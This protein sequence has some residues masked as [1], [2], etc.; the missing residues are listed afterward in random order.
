M[1]GSIKIE[2]HKQQGL[3]DKLE[4]ETKIDVSF[5]GLAVISAMIAC[6]SLLIEDL[7]ILIG[8]MLIAPF[9][10]PP[11]AVGMGLVK[12]DLRLFKKGLITLVF[13]V[14]IG[15]LGVIIVALISPIKVIGDEIMARSAPTLIQLIIAILAG[16][17]GAFSY[18][19]R[20]IQAVLS[21]AF[22]ALALVPPIAIIGIGIAFWN[23]EIVGGAALL[24]AANLIGLAIAAVAVFFLLGFRPIDR[25]ESLHEVKIGITW[26]ALLFFIIVLPLGYIMKSILLTIEQEKQA[27]KIVSQEMTRYPET[28]IDKLVVTKIGEKIKVSFTIHS[29]QEIENATIQG[30]RNQL[31]KKF[32]QEVEVD[33]KLVPTFKIDY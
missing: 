20:K 14:G 19:H 24:L 26:L 18:G 32:K 13:G 31:E 15:I 33:A 25:P 17:A 10:T 27:E 3:L 12:G 11:L 23:W 6:F 22:I 7:P 2:D 1:F 8:A 5:L 4:A 9:L 21:G 29:S 30:I 28:E 16:G